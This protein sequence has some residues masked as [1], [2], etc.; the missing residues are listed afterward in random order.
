MNENT[1]PFGITR[2][3]VL[4][5]AA[6]KLADQTADHEYINNSADK[7]I[8]ERIDLMMKSK[9]AEVIDR[10]VS[11]CVDDLMRKEFTPVDIWGDSTGKP[12]TIRDAL[13]EKTKAFWTAPVDNEGK[14]TEKSHYNSKPRYQYLFANLAKESFAE[15]VTQNITNIVGAL[16]DSLKAAAKQMTDEH[17]NKLIQVRTEGDKR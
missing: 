10:R 5:L 12:I 8:R 11:A 6:R 2:E 3:E 16:K 14:P 17:I 4:E 15:A 7:I 1:N 9:G 13:I